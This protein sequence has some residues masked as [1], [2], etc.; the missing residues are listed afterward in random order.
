M[1]ELKEVCDY[2]VTRLSKINYV[3]GSGASLQFP[4]FQL[5]AYDYLDYAIPLCSMN[6]DDALISC[7]SHLKRAADCQLDTFLEVIG[8][9]KLFSKKNLKFERKLEVIEVAGVFRSSALV[10]L[11]QKRNELEHKYSVPDIEDVQIYYEL[12]WAFVEVL[13]SHMM[14]LHSYGEMHWF[15]EDE[16]QE[17][18]SVKFETGELSFAVESDSLKKEVELRPT[19]E[20]STKLFLQ[21]LNILFMLVR[22][23]RMW[24][25]ER[26][27][28]QL[29]KINFN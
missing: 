17:I 18:L 15:G 12:V 23:D 14:F 10:V 7:V 13:E 2:I 3:E 16:G 6:T 20:I 21:G 11:N 8:L 25:E 29:N 24:P 1:N 22:A 9:G 4:S 27:I 26:V 28:K 19:N 5:T